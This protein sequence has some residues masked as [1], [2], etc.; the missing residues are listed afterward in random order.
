[1]HRVHPS[2]AATGNNVTALVL[3]ENRQRIKRALKMEVDQTTAILLELDHWRART[4]FENLAAYNITGFSDG[5][6]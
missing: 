4:C 3:K 1:M 5:Q 2:T 6:L